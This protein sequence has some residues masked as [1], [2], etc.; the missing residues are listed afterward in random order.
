MITATLL[1]CGAIVSWLIW[2]RLQTGAPRSGPPMPAPVRSAAKRLG[3]RASAAATTAPSIHTAD[4]C[5]ATMAS[6]F[7]QMDDNA[8]PPEALLARSLQKHLGT[9]AP[10]AQDLATLGPWLVDHA[11]GPTPAFQSLTPR[12]KQLDHGPYFDKLMAVMGDVTAAGS[13]GMPNARQADAMGALARVF[14][15]A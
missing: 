5:V 3:Y 11:G 7:A 2:R 1:A 9:S 13:K 15:T 4:L 8:A 10:Q 14:R 6:A 12:L